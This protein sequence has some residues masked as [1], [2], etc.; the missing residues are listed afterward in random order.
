MKK[1]LSLAIAMSLLFGGALIAKEAKKAAAKP[2]AKTETQLI[3]INTAAKAELIKLPGIGDKLADKIINGRPYSKKDELVSKKIISKK[4][5]AKIKD[6]IIA[7]QAG[8]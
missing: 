3:D 5:Y 1:I 4:E 8:K 6:S 7:K 2:A